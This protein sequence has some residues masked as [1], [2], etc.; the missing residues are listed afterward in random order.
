MG[1]GR[2][3]IHKLCIIAKCTVLFTTL[4]GRLAPAFL[5]GI[6]ISLC[7]PRF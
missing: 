7:T 2:G 1:L 4:S 5:D 6:Y 3:G